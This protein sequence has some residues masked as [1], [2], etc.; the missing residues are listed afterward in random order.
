MSVAAFSLAEV[1]D[2]GLT[3][4][5][6]GGQQVQK[7]RETYARAVEALVE[8]ATLQ[9]TQYINAELDELDREEFYRLKKVAKK[10]ERD[11]ASLDAELKRR[12]AREAGDVQKDQPVS[13][14]MLGAEDE[15][16]IF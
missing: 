16:V 7:C 4:L 6:K 2:F 9:L 12:R 10:K 11:N 5:G 13:A 1:T 14:D 8:L 3:G 15:D